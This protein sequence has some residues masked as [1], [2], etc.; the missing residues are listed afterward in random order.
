MAHRSYLEVLSPENGREYASFHLYLPASEDGTYYTRYRFLF[1]ENPVKTEL[2]YETGC[3]DPANR[4][5]YRICTADMVQREGERFVTL[6]RVLSGGEI[7]F[8]IKEEGAGDF[9][10]G[11]HGDEVLTEVILTAD[12]RFVPL[13]K[14]YF[15]SF[16][17]L[18]FYE[19]SYIFRCNTPGEKIILHT[20]TYTVDGDRLLL[21]QNIEWIADGHTLHSG[22]SP[23]LTAQRVNSDKTDE[24]LS[25]T[26]MFYDKNDTLLATFDTTAYANGKDGGYHE[27]GGATRVCAFQ[28]DG[29]LVMET[30]YTVRDGS[31]P[32]EQISA[33]LWIRASDNK[34]YFEITGK[35]TPKQGTAW[36]SDIFYRVTYQP[37]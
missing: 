3:N 33:K 32:D 29:G 1:E 6:F 31:I 18:S 23:M 7:G 16:S 20:Q 26:V 21:A 4:R 12:G 10:G 14:P 9:V 22:F 30:G 27:A 34:A 15:G 35:T 19:Q 17:E 13:D 25:D 28:K 5:F 36:R 11:F 37:K 8:A 2:T 24:V